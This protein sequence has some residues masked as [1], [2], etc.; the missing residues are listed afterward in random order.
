MAV[1]PSTRYIHM[2]SSAKTLEVGAVMLEGELAYRRGEHDKG[3]ELLR[4]AVALELALPYDEP[5]GWMTPV[6]H[7]LGAL[8]TEQKRFVEA[9]RVFRHDLARWPKNIWSLRGL[10]QCLG[11]RRAS[12]QDD[13]SVA[14]LEAELREVAE[15]LAL[16]SARCDIDSDHACFCAGMATSAGP[17]P[18]CDSSV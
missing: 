12:A 10:M 6:E 15:Q 5:W 13:D 16:A 4:H 9:E 11:S 7:A 14:A 1:V 2:V 17:L 3:F 8:L 18:C